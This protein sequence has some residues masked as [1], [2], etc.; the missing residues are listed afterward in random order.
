MKYE[1]LTLYRP[2]ISKRIT[3]GFG[4]NKA[5]TNPKTGDIKGKTKGT[6]P[7]GYTEFYPYIGMKGHNGLDLATWHAEKI[8]HA[9]TYNGWLH[10]DPEEYNEGLGVDVVSNELLFF[11]G[12][13]PE[14]LKGVV[15]EHT[16]NG[17][18]GFLSHVKTRHWHCLSVIGYE[19]QQVTLG[20]PIALADNTGASSGNH[21]H[22]G[23][24]LCDEK[25]NTYL[26][27]K[28]THNGKRLPHNGYTGAFDLTPYFYSDVDAKSAAEYLMGGTQ[29]LSDSEKVQM[30]S[31]LTLLYRLLNAL[32]EIKR[33]L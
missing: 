5:C 21:D 23:A 7:V 10:I 31:R 4:E 20:K 15:K 3:Q 32:L 22:F 27:G 26:N 18:K 25:G 12:E 17:K 33:K 6:C 30:R 14:D 19:G 8:F 29:N 9:G 2:V 24:K 28:Y 16:Q 1:Q 11:P 13:P